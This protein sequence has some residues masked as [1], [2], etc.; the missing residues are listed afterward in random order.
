M[1]EQEACGPEEPS[2]LDYGVMRG[3]DKEH[4]ETAGPRL[5]VRTATQQEVKREQPV[6]QGGHPQ[7]APSV[8]EFMA[9]RPYTRAELVDWGKQFWRRQGEP[10]QLGFCA[11]GTQR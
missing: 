10:R 8:T 11:S 5:A 2:A 7:G 3:D 4:C 9:C 1:L 6:V